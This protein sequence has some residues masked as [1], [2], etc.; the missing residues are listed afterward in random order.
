MS[1][2]V[3]PRTNTHPP[4]EHRYD[5][6]KDILCSEY[7]WDKNKVTTHAVCALNA[8]LVRSLGVFE[9]QLPPS[10]NTHK[11]QVAAIASSPVDLAKTRLM[12]AGDGRAVYRGMF[13]CLSSTARNEGIF[14]LYKGFFP[15]WFRLA[16]WTLMFFL[17]YERIRF[18]LSTFVCVGV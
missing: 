15:N 12:N 3:K 7:N 2:G 1:A 13:H 5:T 6:S 18:G 17:S 11:Q 14:A 10:N 8:G 16:P 9:N 4:I